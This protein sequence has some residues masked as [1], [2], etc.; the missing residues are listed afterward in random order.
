MDRKLTKTDVVFQGISMPMDQYS[1]F[2]ELLPQIEKE[3]AKKGERVVRPQ[4]D[5][6]VEKEEEDVADEEP[7][8]DESNLVSK[9]NIEATSDEEED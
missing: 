2:L 5:R 3:L 8:I 9:S 1:A 7:E 4:Y 6:Q